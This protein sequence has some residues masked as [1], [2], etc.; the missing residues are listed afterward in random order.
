[1]AI[2]VLVFQKC[3][4]WRLNEE[5]RKAFINLATKIWNKFLLFKT[6]EEKYKFLFQKDSSA[7]TVL[8]VDS[9][10]RSVVVRIQEASANDVDP[11]VGS[12]G[13]VA[14]GSEQP[15]YAHHAFL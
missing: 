1:M 9:R 2:N 10:G 15:T 7:C 13:W 3:F 4:S 12:I 11:G 6:D 14:I 8:N 5:Q